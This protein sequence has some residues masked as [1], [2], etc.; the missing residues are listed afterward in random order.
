MRIYKAYG[1]E[2]YE[3][4]QFVNYDEDIEMLN[5]LLEDSPV[6]DKWITPQ[7]EVITK[8]KKSDR[9][10]LWVDTRTLVVSEKAKSELKDIWIEDN[11]ELL[12]IKCNQDIYYLVHIM[13]TENISYEFTDNGIKFAED[14]CI[15]QNIK[16]KYLF[17]VYI[18]GK[19]KDK[20]VFINEKFIERVN[21][22]DLKGFGFKMEW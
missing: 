6:C 13:N 17:K 22:T 19:F 8:G 18:C 9:P 15:K 20:S 1:K 2:E 21:K 10:F 7:V 12:P 4:L 3:E 14:E 16:N 11:I 5:L